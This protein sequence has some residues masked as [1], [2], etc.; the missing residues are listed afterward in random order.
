MQKKIFCSLLFSVDTPNRLCP[1]GCFRSGLFAVLMLYVFSGVTYISILSWGC[2]C[3]SEMSGAGKEPEI[4]APPWEQMAISCYKLAKTFSGTY[5]GILLSTLECHVN[6]I[7][8]WIWQWSFSTM[9]Y[10]G[11]SQ[12]IR[13]WWKSSFFLATYFKKWNFH[14]LDSLHV[15]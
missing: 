12:K 1:T 8:I 10:T 14:I 11:T 9:T 15:K 7:C 4:E 2:R 6:T 3:P 5:H 13:I